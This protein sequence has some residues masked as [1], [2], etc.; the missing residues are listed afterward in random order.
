MNRLSQRLVL[1]VGA[2]CAACGALS[3]AASPLSLSLSQRWG[4]SGACAFLAVLLSLNAWRAPTLPLRW[5]VGT[6]VA[7][8]LALLALIALWLGEGIHTPALAYAGL[9]VCG[10]AVVGGHRLALGVIAATGGLLLVLVLAEQVGWIPG[11]ARN[12]GLSVPLHLLTITAWLMAGLIAGNLIHHAVG[13]EMLDSRRRK[14]RF[15]A[16]L[17]IA[18]DWYWEQDEHYRYTYVSEKTGQGSLLTLSH[19]VGE[20]PW[21]IV[22]FGLTAEQLEAHRATLQARRPFQKLI[23]KRR[24]EQGAV[25]YVSLSG[26]PRFDERRVF[27]GYWGIGRDVTSSVSAQLALAASE[28]RYRELFARSPTPLILHRRGLVLEANEAAATMFGFST[29]QA[30]LGFN[31]L[32]IAEETGDDSSSTNSAPTGKPVG[33]LEHIVSLDDAPPG[34][35]FPVTDFR[36]RSKQGKVISAQATGTR[37]ETAQGAATL[38]LY[39]DITARRATEAALRRSEAVLRLLFA[40]SPDA[41]ILSDMGSQRVTLVNDTF[42]RLTGFY[43]DDVLGLPGNE[44]PIWQDP[45]VYDGLVEKLDRLGSVTDLPA[46]VLGSQGESRSLLLSAA[47]FYVDGA[48]Y[49]VINARDV[50]HA[51]R[52][53][54]QYDAMSRNASIGIAMS[55][56][57]T[58]VQANPCFERMFG[59]PE[60]GM[61]GQPGAVIWRDAAEYE[62]V[63]RSFGSDL[64]RGMRI[65]IERWMSHRNGT[66][67]LCRLMAQAIDLNDPSNGGTIWIAEDVT[68]RHQMT[69]ALAA[70][71]DA[72]EAASRAKTAFLANTSHEVR[73][74]LHGILGLARLAQSPGLDESRRQRYLEQILDSAEGLSHIITDVLDLSKI[75][76]GKLSLDTTVFSLYDELVNVQ[77]SY[78]PLADAKGLRFEFCIDAAVPTTVSGDPVRV[79]QILSNYINNALKFTLEGWVQLDVRLTEAGLVRLMVTDTGPGIDA[80]TQARLFSPF[81]QADESTTRRYGGT[82]LGLSICRELASLMQGRVGVISSPGEGSSFWAELNLPPAQSAP[83]VVD[84]SLDDTDMLRG[85]RVLLVEDNPVNMMIGV[86]LL[87]QWG[88]EVTQA[89]DGHIA[90]QSVHEA[91]AQGHGPDVVL[92][93]VQMPSMSGHEAARQLRQRYSAQMLPIIALTAAALVSEREDALGAGMNDFL[94]KPIDNQRLQQTLVLVLKARRSKNSDGQS[95]A[96]EFGGEVEE[97]TV[98][99]SS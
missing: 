25:H 5:A 20:T 48:N 33:V 32:D 7:A 88:I 68:E 29:P 21:D 56:N 90:V 58:I 96:Q 8:A 14:Q 46:Q 67:F 41:I 49:A 18:V 59:W 13:Q 44:L 89:E 10:A 78:E 34:K 9:L 66:L 16:M 3:Y 36:M 53:R 19:R 54:L 50:T 28:A 22:E 79:R 23:A 43:S 84:I 70:A 15:R 77:R 65:D 35:S 27:Q 81:T 38:S 93:D 94:T 82:G 12:A 64:S 80:A 40:T 55:L 26:E 85:T 11:A 2:L 37:V 1:C 57:R 31:L 24:D 75:E 52:V 83:Q 30:M 45:S 99:G 74:P 87:E 72:A 86:A 62:E 17:R 39:F 95:V 76:A 60:G 63:G 61:S 6:S 97:S 4:V 71:R 92:M 69:Q 51:E 47:R 42:T 91:F 73:T 98:A